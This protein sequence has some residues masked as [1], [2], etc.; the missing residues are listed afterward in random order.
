MEVLA[1]LNHDFFLTIDNGLLI[2]FFFKS[3]DRKITAEG[4]KDVV[5]FYLLILTS[6]NFTIDCS[7]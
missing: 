6:S 3:S 5:L 7:I 4:F 2:P 1:S